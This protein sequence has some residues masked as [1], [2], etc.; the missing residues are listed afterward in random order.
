MYLSTQLKLVIVEK[1][2][3]FLPQNAREPLS[4][5]YAGTFHSVYKAHLSA[6]VP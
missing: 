3:R 4:S 2:M 5:F 1:C 6:M